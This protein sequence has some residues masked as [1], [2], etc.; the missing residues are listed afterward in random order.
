MRPDAKRSVPQSGKSVN[1]SNDRLNTIKTLPMT[2]WKRV[3]ITAPKIIAIASKIMTNTSS[4]LSTKANVLRINSYTTFAA[5]IAAKV[6]IRNFM[7]STLFRI[8]YNYTILY[9][10]M[11]VSPYIF[12]RHRYGLYTLKLSSQGLFELQKLL[13]FKEMEK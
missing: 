10:K 7:I 12:L 5:N 8:R 11:Q 2:L 6:E 13:I 1:M 3:K 4:P 9:K